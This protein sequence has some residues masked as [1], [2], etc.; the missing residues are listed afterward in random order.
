MAIN[1]RPRGYRRVQAPTRGPAAPVRNVP[2]VALQESRELAKLGRTLS[3]IGE[4]F[5]QMAVKV[6]Q[7]EIKEEIANAQTDMYEVMKNLEIELETAVPRDKP[8]GKWGD[9]TAERFDNTLNDVIANLN[10]DTSKNEITQWAKRER[11]N[12]VTKFTL[13]GLRK[14]EENI[15]TN[16][17]K[18]MIVF[19]ESNRRE[20]FNNLVDS[21]LDEETATFWKQRA[22][23]Y[24]VEFQARNLLDSLGLDEAI[25]YVK[26]QK[27]AMSVDER[28][29]LIREL[30]TD[31]K[32]AI[33][34]EKVIAESDKD[35]A[36][37]EYYD[38]LINEGSLDTQQLEE[39][40]TKLGS[41]DW[42]VWQKINKGMGESEAKKSNK[43]I[44]I[45][46]QDKLFDHWSGLTKSPNSKIR[47][48]TELAEAFYSDKDLNRED[49]VELNE[50]INIEIEKDYIEPLRSA[51]EEIADMAEK[52]TSPIFGGKE[53]RTL[54]VRRALTEWLVRER[55]RKKDITPQQ[56]TVRARELFAVVRKPTRKTLKEEPKSEA[57]FERNIIDLYAVGK[58][59]LAK[60]YYDKWVGKFGEGE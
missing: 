43:D 23:E 55:D 36:V 52:K 53:E 30:E 54:K 7:N 14:N 48:K 41:E 6:H 59:D 32:K 49:W 18:K 34:T 4:D 19:T 38:T 56:I 57:D 29:D 13:R 17:S 24:E 9:I 20:E 46:L 28:A 2:E 27:E 47:I 11:I 22:L 10:Y 33:Q 8:Y 21:V 1:L 51:F 42:V 25:K 5:Y 58:T 40:F 16:L 45:K 26:K 44:Y 12:Q 39:D 3:N 50:Y 35:I 15:R 60:Q 37:A 31:Y